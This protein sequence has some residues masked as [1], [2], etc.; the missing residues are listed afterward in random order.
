MY[1][2][3]LEK[4][5]QN[6]VIMKIKTLFMC[7]VALTMV[8]S[9]CNPDKIKDPAANTLTIYGKTYTLVSAF[10]IDQNGR[11]YVDATTVERDVHA[12]P[13]YSII[14]DVE[15]ISYNMTYSLTEASA[16]YYTDIAYYFNVHND[17]YTYSILQDYHTDS[18][19]NGWIGDIEYPHGIFKNG[20]LAISKDKEMFTYKVVGTIVDGQKIS[21]NISVPV[22]EWEYLVW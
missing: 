14:A 1:L 17:D 12:M 22:S 18:G 7:L 13:L 5:N 3:N 15:T 4:F 9:S 21:F 2:C 10:R 16:G 20:T 11:G 6:P 19:I 8:F